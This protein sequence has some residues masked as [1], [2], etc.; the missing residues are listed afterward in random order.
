MGV[1]RPPRSDL[2][3]VVGERGLQA[4]EGSGPL[5]PDGAEVADVE[6]DRRAPTGLVLGDGAIGIGQRH[7]PTTEG[8]HLGAERAVGGV[9]G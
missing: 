9:E 3:E 8:H 6:G 7:V 1:L 2:A 5:H 4:L